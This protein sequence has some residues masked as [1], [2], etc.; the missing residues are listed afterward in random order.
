MNR[1][2]TRGLRNYGTKVR[3]KI[4]VEV[5]QA[6]REP[7]FVW[8]GNS[9]SRRKFVS[10]WEPFRSICGS[11]I[12]FGVRDRWVVSSYVHST[13]IHIYTY[14]FVTY[15]CTRRELDLSFFQLIVVFMF[16]NPKVICIAYRL[17]YSLIVCFCLVRIPPFR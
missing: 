16:S 14:I 10:R 6:G 2:E 5:A 12:S 8:T 7:W 1:N 3:C 15:K 9:V 4:L 17:L 13:Y 11:L